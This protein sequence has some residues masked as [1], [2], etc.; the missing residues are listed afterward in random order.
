MNEPTVSAPDGIEPISA[1]RAWTYSKGGRAKLFPLSGGFASPSDAWEG[2]GS[3]WVTASC[4]RDRSHGAPSEECDCGFYSVKE[5]DSA[6]DLLAPIE[7]S[8]PRPGHE[9]PLV[10]GQILLSGKVIE[11][12]IGFRAQ[13]ARI[14]ELIPF[15]GSERSV[16]RLANKLG[17]VMGAAV[18]PRSLPRIVAAMGLHPRPSPVQPDAQDQLAYRVPSVNHML[19][20]ILIALQRLERGDPDDQKV[21]DALLEALALREGAARHLHRQA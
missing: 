15:R 16:T 21:P 3:K 19:M 20:R 8:E 1:F 5:L 9:R 13:R 6:I 2:A 17:V 14:A 11:H 4:G 18:E 10:L 12:E 7:L